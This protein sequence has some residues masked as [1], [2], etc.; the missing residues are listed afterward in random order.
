MYVSAYNRTDARFTEDQLDLAKSWL[1]CAQ[2]RPLH[3]TQQQ[4]H[5]LVKSRITHNLTYLIYTTHDTVYVRAWHSA[6]DMFGF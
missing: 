4:R 5:S 2:G 1:P 6:L 3:T